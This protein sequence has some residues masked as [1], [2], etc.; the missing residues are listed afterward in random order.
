MGSVLFGHPRDSSHT[1]HIYSVNAWAPPT[2]DPEA[3][4]ERMRGICPYIA[5]AQDA[6][7]GYA[8]LQPNG[9][10][11]HFFGAPKVARK[12]V[13]SAFMQ[14]LHTQARLRGISTLFADVSLTAVAF[15]FTATVG[16]AL[17]DSNMRSGTWAGI[18]SYSR[19][20]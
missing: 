12:G 9:Y 19:F 4:A 2:R 8:D 1:I 6:I 15:C 13:E 10:I 5:V 3:W 11:D 20:G 17:L 7:I 18:T 14:H 16:R